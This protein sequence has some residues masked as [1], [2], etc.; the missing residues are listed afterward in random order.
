M[1][2]DGVLLKKTEEYRQKNGIFVTDEKSKSYI[3]FKLAATLSFVWVVTTNILVAINFLYF[4]STT[5]VKEDLQTAIIIGAITLAMIT[6]YVFLMCGNHYIG[7]P[8]TAIANMAAFF[9]FKYLQTDVVGTYELGIRESFYYRHAIPIILFTI[10]ILAL[11]YIGIKAKF[12]LKRDAKA[13]VY[14]LYATF[15][16]KN[17][18]FSESDWHKYL[19]SLG[20]SE[21]TVEKL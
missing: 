4:R 14:K 3:G 7:A 8:V 6:G 10:C 1:K 15:K 5:M 9:L 13:V 11:A 12:L 21:K 17:P 19:N 18:D 20:I 16:S 2:I